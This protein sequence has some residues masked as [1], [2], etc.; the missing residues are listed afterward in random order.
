M[1]NFIID[2]LL[3]TNMGSNIVH[4]QSQINSPPAFYCALFVFGLMLLWALMLP[5]VFAQSAEEITLLDFG[6][7]T[8]NTSSIQPNILE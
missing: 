1:I 8:A 6:E 3:K 4:K 5:P 2:I 7:P